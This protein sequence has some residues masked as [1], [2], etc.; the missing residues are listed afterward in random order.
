MKYSLIALAL[1]TTAISTAQQTGE[2]VNPGSLYQKGAPNVLV[3]QVARREGDIITIL[4]EEQ[5]LSTF[6]ASTQATKEDS[7]RINAS[8][9]LGFLDDLFR[10]LTTGLGASSSV[11][12]D[13]S[14]Q[15]TGRMSARMSAV[16][17][18]VLPNG[19]MIIEGT[20]SLI[21]NKQTQTFVLSGMIRPVDIS[22]DNTIRSQF[23]AE[24]S[25]KM[26]GKG[27][28]AERQRKGILTQLLDW[29]F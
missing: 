5:S 20:R 13:G 19:N 15:Q 16:V 18:A 7:S 3:D 24:A 2:K 28:V 26:D 17:K 21:T 11:S 9:F 6:A 10:P 4:I 29:L 22:P 1:I 14:T 23:I 27:M 12:G 25:I 8:F